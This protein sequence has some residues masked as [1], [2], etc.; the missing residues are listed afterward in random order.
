[1]TAGERDALAA[2]EVD[3]M[4]LRFAGDALCRAAR[5]E[6]IRAV[7]GDQRFQAHVIADE[8]RNPD[9]PL[10]HP[11]SVLTADLVD[12]D[13]SVTKQKLLEVIAFLNARLTAS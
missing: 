13:D 4:A 8:H 1:M 5:F 3:V 12:S 11:H 10:R 9:G 6:A 2:R 7:V